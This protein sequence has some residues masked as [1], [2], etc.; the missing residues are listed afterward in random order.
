MSGRWILGILLAAVVVVALATPAASWRFQ[1]FFAFSGRTAATVESL[2]IES[3]AARLPTAAQAYTAAPVYSRYP[4]NVK[5]ELLVGVGSRDGVAPGAIAV[6][7]ASSSV[8]AVHGTPAPFVLLGTVLTVSETD[9]VIETVFD[10]RLT[11]AVRVG[12]AAADALFEGGASP[13]LTT[14]AKGA[15]V[16]PGNAIVAA[17]AGFPYGLAVGTVSGV[18]DSGSQPFREA[19]VA[20]PYDVSGLRVVFIIP[21]NAV[22]P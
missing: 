1:R 13:K 21:Q 12:A 15:A 8:S 6:V 16:A 7:A 20:V 4:F 9:A 5:S 10:P 3:V 2:E 18:A 19:A 22:T 14:I 17:A 11:F